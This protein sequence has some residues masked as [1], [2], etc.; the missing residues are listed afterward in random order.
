MILQEA[1]KEETTKM[2]QILDK[3]KDSGNWLYFLCFMLCYQRKR[4]MMIL[5]EAL[6]EKM[7]KLYQILDEIER[8]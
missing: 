8:R 6:K 1:M 4:E 3:L 7:T 2:H 5:Q